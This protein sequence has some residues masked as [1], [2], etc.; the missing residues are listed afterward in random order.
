MNTQPKKQRYGLSIL[1][2]WIY[3]AF[4]CIWLFC[5]LEFSDVLF[6]STVKENLHTIIIHAIFVLMILF[7]ILMNW[8]Y[9]NSIRKKIFVTK[10]FFIV[11]LIP[12]IVS[13]AVPTAFYIFFFLFGLFLKMLFT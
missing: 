11:R 8:L 7:N 12:I 9:Y 13:V 4:A 3:G 2:N 6:A 5:A 10:K 1:L